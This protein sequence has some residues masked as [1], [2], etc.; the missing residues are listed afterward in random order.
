MR[1]RGCLTKWDARLNSNAWDA[2]FKTKINRSNFISDSKNKKTEERKPLCLSFPS[3]P[4]FCFSQMNTEWKWKWKCDLLFHL[5]FSSCE[6]FQKAILPKSYPF[7]FSFH[8]FDPSLHSKFAIQSFASFQIPKVLTQL[9]YPLISI[10][11][12]HIFSSIGENLKATIIKFERR[13]WVDQVSNK[14]SNKVSW[15]ETKRFCEE[16]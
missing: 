9:K 4:Y 13:G 10:V 14:V 11:L 1:E 2:L 6:S 5:S 16:L 15:T 8:S 3:F 7:L 12:Y